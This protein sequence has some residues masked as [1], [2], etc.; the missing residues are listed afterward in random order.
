MTMID[1]VDTLA[2]Y[3]IRGYHCN[4]SMNDDNRRRSKR[5]R[6]MAP[7]MSPPVPPSL[8]EIN[9]LDAT[10]VHVEQFLCIE[11]TINLSKTC[12]AIRNILV[13][14][15]NGA[16]TKIKVSHFEVVDDNAAVATAA[17]ALPPHR[18]INNFVSNALAKIHFP[19]LQRLVINF[20][21]GKR[22]DELRDS[23]IYLALGLERAVNL[24][25][26]TVDF[27][28]FLMERNDFLSQ[29]N[30]DTLSA[31]LCRCTK[32]KR[33]KVI[34]H[35]EY[36]VRQAGTRLI[37]SFYSFYSPYLLAAFIPAIE[38]G[39]STI[40]GV[41]FDFGKNLP[42]TYVGD[43]SVD[44]SNVV[45]ESNDLF[46]KI[47]LCNKLKELSLSFKGE[48]V[49]LSPLFDSF[50]QVS[51]DIHSEMDGDLP[52]SSIEKM[53]IKCEEVKVGRGESGEQIRLVTPW[54][55]NDFSV[56]PL[57]DM[58]SKQRNL[59]SSNVFMDGL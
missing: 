22:A 7:T 45:S 10:I 23:F 25:E 14:N 38:Q 27:T 49:D 28:P 29:N 56:A 47:L 17:P 31:N 53:S 9:A 34:N 40:E 42:F 11:D 36:R 52:S 57:M 50:L 4:Y 26:L 2:L 58:I 48:E 33:L 51:R 55:P 5:L 20:R 32:L 12:H 15:P 35:A 59:V 46:R 43:R 24:E 18:R 16:F 3:N 37:G 13:H 21:K 30:Y 39:V 44:E 19:T 41:S 54:K 8:A 6:L 1:S